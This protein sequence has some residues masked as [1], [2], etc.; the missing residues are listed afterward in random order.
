MK[1]VGGRNLKIYVY[2]REKIILK[3]NLKERMFVIGENVY[4][5]KEKG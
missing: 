5:D 3:R 2:C 1:N 4:E